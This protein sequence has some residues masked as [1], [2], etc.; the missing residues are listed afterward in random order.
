MGSAPGASGNVDVRPSSRMLTWAAPAVTG[1]EELP[2]DP[3]GL[4]AAFEQRLA[5]GV[6][7][8]RRPAQEPLVDGLGR[9][10][11][12]EQHLELG[13]V[14]AAVEELGFLVLP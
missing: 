14:D 11:R 1:V 4:D 10:Q 7:H 2:V 8:L 9:D 5:G 6:D 13:A 3:A 12:V